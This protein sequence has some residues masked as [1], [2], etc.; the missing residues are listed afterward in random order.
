M[1]H[2]K[3]LSVDELRAFHR[4][5]IEADHLL[6]ECLRDRLPLRAMLGRFLPAL[7]GWMGAKA[8]RL[9]T[10]DEHLQHETFGWGESEL[11]QHASE[12]TGDGV[13]KLPSGDTLVWQPLDLAGSEVG[14]IQVLIAGDRTGDTKILRVML[15][16]ACEELDAVLAGVHAAAHKQRLIVAVNQALTNPVFELGIDTAVALIHKEICVPEFTLLYRDAVDTQRFHYRVYAHGQLCNDSERNPHPGIERG[17][18]RHGTLLLDPD[19]QLMRQT[20]GY[21]RGVDAVLISGMTRS[22]WLGKVLCTGGEH[23]FSTFALDVVEVMCES[24]GQRLVDFNR[25]RRHLAQFFEAK[26]I[27]E[28]L[29]DPSY[30]ERFLAPR[31]ETIAVLYAD[32]NS[33]TKISEQVLVDSSSIGRFVDRWSAGAV[34]LLWDHGGVFDKM[35]GD[36]I[37]G[38]FGPPFFREPPEQR[39][40]S[41]VKAARAISRFTAELEKEP[42]YEK[43]PQSGVV[44][45]MGVAIG[46]NLCAMSVGLFGPNQDYTGFSSG[47]NSTARLQS[48]AGFR[49]TLGMESFCEALEKTGDNVLQELK[50]G[51]WTETPV[52]NVK[53][54][55]RYRMI[56]FS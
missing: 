1:D 39:A 50:F 37:I 14:R 36:C 21:A 12:R 44:K 45:G 48:L 27:S 30:A 20:V 13:V 16:A 29:R 26:V 34:Q 3:D 43:V 31:E 40:L 53:K 19:Q 41:A 10:Q 55:L 47:M 8:A 33:F 24:I 32:I 35:V 28:L 17:L 18:K 51:D 54:P 25:E 52:K 56:H 2:R 23:G 42:L 38:H 49:E 22:E 11:L 9:T 5:A 6:E 15:D 46:L 7:G 4:V